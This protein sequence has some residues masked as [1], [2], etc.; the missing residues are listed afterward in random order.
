M[1]DVIVIGYGTQKRG[2]LTG[3]V[4]TIKAAEIEDIPAQNIAGAL[5]GRIA[6]LG[7]SAASGRPGASITLNVRDA[8]SSAAVGG[9]S[10]EPLYVIDNMIVSQANFR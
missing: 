8:F 2:K 3:A 5:R 10:D 1:D 4:A 9:A 7:V 6:G